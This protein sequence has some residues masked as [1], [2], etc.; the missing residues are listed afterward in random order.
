MGDTL[1]SLFA[2]RP[3]IDIYEDVDP[4]RVPCWSANGRMLLPSPGLGWALAFHVR[5]RE[6]SFRDP[7]RAHR[8]VNDTDS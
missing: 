3:C 8:C 5:A 1:G 6:A 2:P 4:L 7:S